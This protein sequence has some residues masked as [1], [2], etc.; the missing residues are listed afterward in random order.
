VKKRKNKTRT[1]IKDTKQRSSE[2]PELTYGRNVNIPAASSVLRLCQS[3]KKGRYLEVTRDIKIGQCLSL[4]SVQNNLKIVGHS[5]MALKL[6]I[7]GQSHG[8]WPLNYI[9]G[10]EFLAG[11]DC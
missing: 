10:W 11:L 8:Y 7:R 1:K 3:P 9:N 4:I 2:V 5:K 6:T